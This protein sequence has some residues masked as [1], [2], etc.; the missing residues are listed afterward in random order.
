MAVDDHGNMYTWGAND[1]GQLGNES[2]SNSN[3]PVLFTKNKYASTCNGVQKCAT[4][5]QFLQQ[6]SEQYDIHLQLA[7]DICKVV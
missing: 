4:I 3:V 7:V 2:T 5:K 6:S 1:K